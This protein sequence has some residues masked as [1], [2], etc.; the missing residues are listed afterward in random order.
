MNSKHQKITIS[1]EN[2]IFEALEAE[3]G[4]IKRSSFI[5]NALKEKFLESLDGE[6]SN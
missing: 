4:P 1:L 5:N 3:R 2:K 6:A